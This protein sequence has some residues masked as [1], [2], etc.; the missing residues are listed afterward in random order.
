M[1]PAD[2]AVD[3]PGTASLSIT[4]ALAASAAQIPAAPAGLDMLNHQH[5]RTVFTYVLKSS[6]RPDFN[7]PPCAG[8]TEAAR[9][10]RKE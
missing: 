4:T 7:P 5:C 6:R 9:C 8:F 1:S 2:R 10:L 3:P